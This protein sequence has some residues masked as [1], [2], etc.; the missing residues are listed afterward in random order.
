MV[1]EET[2]RTR[3][4]IL[5]SDLKTAALFFLSASTFMKEKNKIFLFNPSKSF[6]KKLI[7]WSQSIVSNGFNTKWQTYATRNKICQIMGFAICWA[8]R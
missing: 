6:L 5:P 8:L 4:I 2:K 3:K 1:E 7:F